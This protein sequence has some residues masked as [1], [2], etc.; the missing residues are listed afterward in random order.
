MALPA[1]PNSLSFNQIRYE[2]GPRIGPASI[3]SYRVSQTTVPQGG[4]LQ[5]LPLDDGVPQ[6]GQIGVGN[7]FNKRL[8]VLVNYF[9]G[10]STRSTARADFDSQNI[11]VVGGLLDPGLAV[12]TSSG[13]RVITHVNKTIGSQKSTLNPYICALRTGS[14]WETDTD[15]EIEVGSSG[16]IAGA[17]GDGG[18]AGFTVSGRDPV[19][20]INSF[21][22]E[23][24][25]IITVSG[26]VGDLVILVSAASTEITVGAGLTSVGDEPLP[27]GFNE[28]DANKLAPNGDPGLPYFKISYKTMASSSEN[29]TGLTTT[30]SIHVASV[31]RGFQDFSGDVV[32]DFNLTGTTVTFPTVS[33][34]AQ[35]LVF[36]YGIVRDDN[37]APVTASG[38]YN[39][40]RSVDFGSGNNVNPGCT[41]VLGYVNTTAGGS[42]SP[43]SFTSASWDGDG[44]V[45]GSI[46]LGGTALGSSNV[47]GQSGT[48][49]LGIQY[50]CTINNAGLI[51]SGRGGGGAGG[52]GRGVKSARTQDG[53]E[54][55]GRYV[56]GGGGGGGGGRGLPGGTGGSRDEYLG[57]DNGAYRAQNGFN[58]SIDSAGAGGLGGWSG[59]RSC[60]Q[61]AYGGTGGAGGAGGGA[62]T[63]VNVTTI[64]VAG[65]DG[66][67]IVV[68]S[69][70]PYTPPTGNA[71]NGNVI[72]GVT[73]S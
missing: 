59:N 69:G 67:A 73:V 46:P 42:V 65:G 6:S 45:S 15:L 58:G 40:I 16:R 38:G 3:G 72:G 12:T 4:S 53:C 26:A 54:G 30:N 27:S 64:G 51:L 39:S 63:P 60:L 61:D 35:S 36:V 68:N 17:G 43:G 13:R 8:N 9:S 37:I 2:F 33:V 11:V 21:G 28:I 41:V 56:Y 44:W 22:G 19:S 5:N 7:F 66:A 57:I 25:G 47:N 29:I 48:S 31:F 32:T 1:A 18:D 62:G 70:V 55:F 50:P 23:S 71:P 20:F 10:D 52:R 24:V 14:G 34:D 49:A